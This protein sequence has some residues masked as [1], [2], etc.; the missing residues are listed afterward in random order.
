MSATI[1]GQVNK[2]T[3]YADAANSL[4][5]DPFTGDLLMVYNEQSV[6][7]AVVNVVRTMFYSRPYQ[8]MIGSSLYNTLFEPNDKFASQALENTIKEAIANFESRAVIIS[9][10]CTIVPPQGLNINVIFYTTTSSTPQSVSL[11]V[12]RV[13]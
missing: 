6:K 9:V 5:A 7:Q 3:V 2:Y 10:V 4:Q 12:N 11:T 1:T 8:P 13:R